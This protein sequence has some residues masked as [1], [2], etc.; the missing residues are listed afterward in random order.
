MRIISI[1]WGLSSF[2]RDAS[3]NRYRASGGLFVTGPTTGELTTTSG[4]RSAERDI[5]CAVVLAGGYA[6]DVRANV[7]IHYGTACS[8]LDHWGAGRDGEHDP[9]SDHQNG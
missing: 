8:L 1:R 9:Q 5:P 6:P 7:T 2:E 3:R 4:R